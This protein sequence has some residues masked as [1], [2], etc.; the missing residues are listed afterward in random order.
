MTFLSFQESK[1]EIKK[2]G[3]QS[4]TEW[5]NFCKSNLRPDN[6]PANPNKVYKD[7]WISM[8]DWLGT[9]KI[10]NKDR[11]FLPFL[12]A[13]KFALTLGLRNEKE[14]RAWKKKGELP[15]N[16][17]AKPEVAYKDNGWKGYVDFLRND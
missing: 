7:E 2:Y 4:G 5:R 6:L 15:S 9:G 17:P 10:A 3:L 16:I 8:G 14:W 12:D 13:K 1:K 11:K